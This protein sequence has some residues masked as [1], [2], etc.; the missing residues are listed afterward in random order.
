MVMNSFGNRNFM[1]PMGRLSMH[2]KCL[3]FFLLSFGF[4]GEGG[5][6]SFFSLFPTCSLQVPNGF[7]S[8]SN[9]FLGSQCVPTMFPLSS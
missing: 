8:D 3:D 9:M 2:S 6:F 7:P 4:G 1:Q 5:F